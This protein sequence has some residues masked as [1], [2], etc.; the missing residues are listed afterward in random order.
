M[1]V[2]A[3]VADRQGCERLHFLGGRRGR[4]QTKP[5]GAGGPEMGSAQKQAHDELRETQ[6]SSEVRL[7]FFFF[8]PL[9]SIL[10]TP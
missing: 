5:A 8:V 3:G 1:A 10:S 2:S 7:S 4:V 9:C 6:Q